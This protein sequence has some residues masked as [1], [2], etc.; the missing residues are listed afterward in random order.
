MELFFVTVIGACIGAIARYTLPKRHAYGAFLLPAIG[1]IAAAVV[2]VA[3]LWA[4][5]TFDGTWIWVAS[6]G[7]ALVVALTLA[8]VLP[9]RRAE[10][11]AAKLHQLSGGKV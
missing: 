11:D 1:G 8:V 3:L 9:R 7:V 2:W 10:Q 6:L 5:L 4:G